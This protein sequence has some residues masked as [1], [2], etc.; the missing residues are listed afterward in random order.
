MDT[1]Y[2]VA[3]VGAGIAGCAIARQISGAGLRIV[4][5]DSRAD[6]GEGASVV[7]QGIW[8]TGFDTYP[9][10]PLST[11]VR[12]GYALV[13]EFAYRA[14]IPI[15]KTGAIA[16]AWDDAELRMLTEMERRAHLNG[17]TNTRMLTGQQ[18]RDIEYALSGAVVG[19]LEVPEE[20]LLCPWTTTLAF[21]TQAAANGVTFQFGS[22]VTA[23]DR[24]PDLTWR[25]TLGEE[26][27]VLTKYVVNAA[28][29]HVDDINGMFGHGEFAIKPRKAQSLLFDRLAR[30]LFSH[31]IMP[32]LG[33]QGRAHVQPTIHGGVLVGPMLE[34]VADKSDVSV[35]PQGVDELMTFADAMAPRLTQY[36]ITSM[37]AGLIPVSDQNDLQITAQPAQ[38]Y[39]CVGAIGSRG[40][41][42]SMAIAEHVAGLLTHMG[43]HVE[44]PVDATIPVMP[45]IG[46][47][48]LRPYQRAEVVAS[49]EAYGD[50]VCFCERVTRGEVRDAV[51]SPLPPSSVDGVMRRTRA[52]MGRCQGAHCSAQVRE[53]M[54]SS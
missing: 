41:T 51:A 20:G 24:L 15:E 7:N 33:A 43:L 2:D 21:A 9:G 37:H 22:T 46:E 4:V 47:H 11:F 30:P 16:V 52:T 48:F 36:E 12:R 39:V 3:I 50:I 26:G 19:G 14:N 42:A 35:T 32:V 8:H 28:G 10:S 29:I 6:V 13:S 38:R 17:Y 54:R 27:E 34:E 5:L 44:E 45:N 18:V 23:V 25:L 40:L 53:L 49:D 31:I 1:A